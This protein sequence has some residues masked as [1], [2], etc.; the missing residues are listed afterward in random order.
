MSVLEGY[1]GHECALLLDH[2]LRTVVET[3][4]D[5]LIQLSSFSPAFIKPE[6]G[7]TQPMIVAYQGHSTLDY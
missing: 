6:E 7:L 3:R 1:S 2:T 5:T 4:I